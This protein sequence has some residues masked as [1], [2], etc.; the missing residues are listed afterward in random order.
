M[1]TWKKLG[2]FNISDYINNG[3]VSIE[4]EFKIVKLS[5]KGYYDW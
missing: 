2:V 1:K 3:N 4:S 5:L